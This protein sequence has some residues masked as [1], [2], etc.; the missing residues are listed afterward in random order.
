MGV[1][2]AAVRGAPRRSG[3]KPAASI[4]LHV[5]L[6][7]AALIAVFPMLWIV[8]SSFKHRGDIET[9]DLQILPPEWTAENYDKVLTRNDHEFL[10][11]LLNSVTIA[12]FTTIVGVFLAATAG[13]AFS[14]FRFPGYRAALMSFLIAQ[15]FPGVILLVPIY[16]IVVDLGLL[17]TKTALVL[18]YA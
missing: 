4:G 15:M 11:W 8:L 14:R 12:F 9:P 3:R 16:K 10:H 13:Y 1:N 18:A 6:L 5:T 2:A 7:L 17:N